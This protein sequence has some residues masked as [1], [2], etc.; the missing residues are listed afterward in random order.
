VVDDAGVQQ[1]L[2]RMRSVDKRWAANTSPVVIVVD[3][4]SGGLERA[5]GV[6]DAVGI[7]TRPFQRGS[8]ALVDIGRDEPDAALIAADVTDIAC[9]DWVRAAREGT[10]IPVLVGVDDQHVGQIVQLYQ[11]GATA[12]VG[13]PFDALEVADVLDREWESADT[14]HVT[15]KHLHA[16]PLELD[17]ASYRVSARGREV[18]LTL[19]S[20]ELLWCLMVR[21]NRV[22][23]ADEISRCLGRAPDA[24][25]A[26]AFVKTHVA[27]L[28]SEL[29]DHGF[30]R[31]VR[32]HGYTLRHLLTDT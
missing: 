10:A 8:S 30:I 7:A 5:H 22:V 26:S 12:A 11:A 32:G 17:A 1:R 24:G 19:T 14:R 20:F 27:R 25:N 31:T 15:R 2:L 9:A 16:G 3:E 29:G 28:R 21:A 18:H 13:Y 23:S 4:S 6:L